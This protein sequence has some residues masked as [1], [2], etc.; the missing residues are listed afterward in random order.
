M[1]YFYCKHVAY[2]RKRAKNLLLALAFR[3]GIYCLHMEG[4]G[5]KEKGEERWKGH[6]GDRIKH[7]LAFFRIIHLYEKYGKCN[8]ISNGIFWVIICHGEPCIFLQRYQGVCSVYSIGGVCL[9]ERL[10]LSHGRWE[11]EMP[12]PDGKKE[13][14]RD[15]KQ[16]SHINKKKKR[17]GDFD[18]Q[19]FKKVYMRYIHFAI[20]LMCFSYCFFCFVKVAN[21]KA[22]FFVVGTS[23]HCKGIHMSVCIHTVIVG[24][25]LLGILKRRRQL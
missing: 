16:R 19:E 17:N 22:I 20:K 11:I 6:I 12:N 1:R 9:E 15:D 24:P 3:S 10:R 25:L 18:C 23:L 5:E 8:R 14:K 2:S 7:I 4:E 21:V 13:K